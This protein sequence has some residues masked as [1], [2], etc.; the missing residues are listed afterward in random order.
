MAPILRRG[1]RPASRYSD[2]CGV[3][4]AVDQDSNTNVAIHPSPTTIY[5]VN[6]SVSSGAGTLGL[7]FL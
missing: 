4:D 2:G 1:D 5:W 3:T 7:M 6:V